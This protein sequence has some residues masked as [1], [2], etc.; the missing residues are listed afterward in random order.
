MDKLDISVPA[1]DAVVADNAADAT[2]ATLPEVSLVEEETLPPAPIPTA[3]LPV[4]ESAPVP[5][6]ASNPPAP[7]SASTPQ[8]EVPATLPTPT[9]DPLFSNSSDL[10]F[11]DRREMEMEVPRGELAN[12]RIRE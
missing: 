12:R 6:V 3:S 9:P 1:W 8:G 5:E 11:H 10:N 4:E 2:V 7:V